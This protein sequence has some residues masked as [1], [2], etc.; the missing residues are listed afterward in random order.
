MLSRRPMLGINDLHK[1]AL[2]SKNP[3]PSDIAFNSHPALY[4]AHVLLTPSDDKAII[5]ET[6]ETIALG[7]DRRAIMLEKPGTVKPVDYNSLNKSYFVPQKELSQ[8]QVFCQVQ[9]PE[10]TPFVHTRPKRCQ[11]FSRI[12]NMKKLI[13]H[14]ERELGYR[15][16]EKPY[17]VRD[18]CFT[19]TKQ[20]VEEV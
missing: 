3:K 14:V 15:L 10:K 12:N 8:E 20:C 6:E 2:G 17:R 18:C 7:A 1:T 19:H 4:D 16:S 5:W 11:I 13:T 9:S